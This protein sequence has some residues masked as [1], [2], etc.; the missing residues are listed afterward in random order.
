VLD[1][2]VLPTSPLAG[3][4]IVVWGQAADAARVVS[5]IGGVPAKVVQPPT[6]LLTTAIREIWANYQWIT[7]M[8]PAVMAGPQRFLTALRTLTDRLLGAIAAD[9]GLVVEVV[10]SDPVTRALVRSLYPDAIQIEAS[11]AA[12]EALPETLARSLDARLRQRPSVVR[13]PNTRRDTRVMCIVGSARSGT[14][15]MSRLLQLHPDAGGIG[16][17]ESW[18]FH[19]LAPLWKSA[20][21]G[22][23]FAAHLEPRQMNDALR[24][25]CDD[26]FDS[27]LARD[28]PSATLFVE[29]T[30]AHAL[31]I[32]MIRA[33]YPDAYC[34]HLVRDGRDVARSLSDMGMAGYPDPGIAASSWRDL[35]AAVRR[36][37]AGVDNLAEVR[38]EALVAD[39]IAEVC[40][41]AEWSGLPVDSGFRADIARVAGERVSTWSGTQFSLGSESWRALS[42]WQLGRVYAAAGQTLVAESYLTRSD[43]RRWRHRPE[44][45]LPLLMS[46]ARRGRPWAPGR[47][48]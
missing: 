43:F 29:K 13:R 14:T 21:P 40:R 18:L 28:A 26:M 19:W 10:R 20:G 1:A 3:R 8:G 22:G 44:Y 45:V 25:F 36:D 7:H 48:P 46:R 11:S 35:L 30:P 24:G 16:E 42:S 5:V 17:A 23:L 4:L 9:A 6:E 38:Y 37:A 33:L 34:V 31:C 47:R 27:A 12:I 39:P 41:I 15:W 2:S 32:P